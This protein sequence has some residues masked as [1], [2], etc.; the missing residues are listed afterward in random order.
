MAHGAFSLGFFAILIYF[1]IV[2]FTKTGENKEPTPKKLQRNLVYRIC[3]ATMILCIVLA[4]IYLAQDCASRATLAHL[5]P[6]YWMETI[7]IITFGI[8]WIV[9]GEAIL[10]DAK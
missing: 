3:G 5:N 9:K 2:L 8:S 4:S 1:S 10:A 7:A 6:V